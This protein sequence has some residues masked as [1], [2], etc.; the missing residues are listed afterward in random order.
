MSD[1]LFLK[2]FEEKNPRNF[3]ITIRAKKWH[4]K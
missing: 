1:P 3:K 2:D 4:N